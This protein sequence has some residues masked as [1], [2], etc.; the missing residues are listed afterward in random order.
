MVDVAFETH[1]VREHVRR[2]PTTVR[3]GIGPDVGAMAEIA[4]RLAIDE[5][6]IR[7]QRG[8]DGLQGQRHAQ[9][10]HHV[11]FRGEIEADLYAAGA[12]HH[13]QAEGADLWH[14]PP[15]DAVALLRHPRHFRACGGRVEA[16]PEQADPDLFGHFTH[17]GE[18]G[19]DLAAALVDIVELFPR[20]FQL[21][22]R[23]QRDAGACTLQS[24]RLTVLQYRCPAMAR[25]ALQEFTDPACF[26]VARGSVIRPVKDE[27]LVLGADMPLLA[28]FAARFQVGSK[29]A[30]VGD[31]VGHRVGFSRHHCI[32]GM[33]RGATIGRTGSRCKPSSG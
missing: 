13:V 10:A 32:S 21:T 15:H 9:L 7:K 19:V 23:L 30:L 14:V 8:R 22:G 26:G 18:V 24:D 4:A 1:A 28:R 29:L 12:R 17:F 3:V 5:R 11:R 16:D 31:Y 20:Q 25:H 2:Q 33:E 6:R 27:L